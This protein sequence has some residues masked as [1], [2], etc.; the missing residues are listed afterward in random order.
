[1]RGRPRDFVPNTIEHHALD[2]GHR[3]SFLVLGQNIFVR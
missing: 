2:A 3:R 1:M